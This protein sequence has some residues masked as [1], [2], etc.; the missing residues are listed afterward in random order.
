MASRKTYFGIGWP[1][2]PGDP[3]APADPADQSSP[4]VVDD[5]K[6][7][8]GLKTLRSWYSSDDE[9]KSKPVPA[10]PVNAP[11]APELPQARPTAVG[12]ATGGPLPGA[13]RPVAPDPMRATMFGHDVHRFDLDALIAASEAAPQVPP[14]IDLPPPA[15]ERPERRSEPPR[16][17]DEPRPQ[18]Y[19][20]PGPG[21]G[22]CAAK[23]PQLGSSQLADYLRRHADR[24]HEVTPFRSSLDDTDAH[25]APRVPVT[26]KIVLIAG[27][28]ALLVAILLSLQARSVPEH[29]RVTAPASRTAATGLESLPPRPAP[30]AAPG[31]EQPAA[32][33]P[34]LPATTPVVAPR[35]ARPT[36]RVVPAALRAP[37]RPREA[38]PSAEESGGDETPPAA[39]EEAAPVPPA[40]ASAASAPAPVSP[41]PPVSPPPLGSAPAAAPTEATPPASAAR[42]RPPAPR[43]KTESRREKMRGLGADSDET[44][45]PSED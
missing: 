25:P 30:E 15:P 36:A 4:T 10:Q 43:K 13:S 22:A 44:L 6:V 18:A 31:V 12:H 2:E 5:E 3:A 33:A 32:L 42:E 9:D 38:R 24:P 7:A 20:D 11:T 27:V 19:A 21:P 1:S 14:D 37:V 17:P 29:E 35:P 23:S 39:A 45:P 8:E 26:A 28:A 41:L 40:A 16:Q 34:A